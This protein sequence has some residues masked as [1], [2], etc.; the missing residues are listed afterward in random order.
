MTYADADPS[1]QYSLAEPVHYLQEQR[2]G[3][4]YAGHATSQ[5]TMMGGGNANAHGMDSEAA[6]EQQEAGE[7]LNA[8]Q[9]PGVAMLNGEGAGLHTGGYSG[10]VLQHISFQAELAGG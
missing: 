4:A 1:Q 6:G 8:G 9:L 10:E 2:Q 7:M 3:E 5:C